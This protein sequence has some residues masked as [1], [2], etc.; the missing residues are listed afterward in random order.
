VVEKVGGPEGAR[1]PDPLV[2]NQVLSQLSYRPAQSLL[3]IVTG[4]LEIV[5][6]AAERHGKA[7]LISTGWSLKNRVE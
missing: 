5:K 3:F 6:T 7:S 4:N 1:T 2:A